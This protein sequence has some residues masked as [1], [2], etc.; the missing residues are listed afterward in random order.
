[1]GWASEEMI[2]LAQE[3]RA[4]QDA[5]P[6]MLL[7]VVN[8]LDEISESLNHTLERFEPAEATKV[9]L[10]HKSIDKPTV[11]R[12]TAALKICGFQPWIDED[13]MP[14]GSHLDA[15]LVNGMKESCAAVFFITP[16]FTDERFL[17]QEIEYAVNE[18]RERPGDFV[19]IPLLIGGATQSNVPKLLS[20]FVAKAAADDL[21]GLVE[22]V[23]ALPIKPGPPVARSHT[24]RTC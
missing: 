16:N 10:S 1:M 5:L 15:S 3:R 8:K 7:G 12:Y 20:R 9:F 6:D 18:E 19:I 14:A 11:S 24:T 4:K 21:E 17:K 2:R 23:K 22:I 13:E